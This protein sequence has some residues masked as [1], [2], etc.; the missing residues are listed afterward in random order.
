MRITVAVGRDIGIGQLGLGTNPQAS[1][2]RARR[3][4]QIKI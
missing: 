4:V 1:L 3:I 2:V